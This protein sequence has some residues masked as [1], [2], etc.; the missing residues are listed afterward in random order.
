M[1]AAVYFGPDNLL[2][3][4]GLT[5][6]DNARLVGKGVT[7]IRHWH[8]EGLSPV[9]VQISRIKDTD[10]SDGIR[11]ISGLREPLHTFTRLEKMFI[12]SVSDAVSR[13]PVDLG[14]PRTLLVIS[15][16]KGNIDLLE[17]GKARS[18]EE[19][20][21]HLWRMAEVIAEYF[22]HPGKPLV[23]CNACISGSVAIAMA[24]RMIQS[25][26]YDDAVVSGGDVISEFVISGFQ[27]FQALSPRPCKPFDAGRDGLSLGEGVGTLILSN[28]PRA[29][30][31]EEPIRYLGGAC[32][33]DANHISG[34]S[35]DGKGLAQ[36][37]RAALAEAGIKPE[38][39]DFISAH[40]TATLYND[41]MESLA[42]E[43]ARVNHAPVNSFKGFFG[44]TL[45]AAGVIES[46]LT[47]F[48]MRTGQLFASAGYCDHGV[49]VSLDVLAENRPATARVSL[50]TASGFGGCNAALVF[51]TI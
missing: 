42:F 31:G 28:S 5:T 38:A 30:A 47:L 9:P 11:K 21:I 49:S 16:T 2:T 45:G 25:G 29:A 37:I 7:G 4:L 19:A 41:E 3:P 10:L 44:H 35:R 15:S 51:G 27:S 14:S 23:I 12:A 32:S 6:E 33:N 34:P 39:V 43:L 13:S 48:S 46:V 17:S 20:R 8:D 40:G 50:K 1:A 26:K 24:A 18:F 22:G 36:A